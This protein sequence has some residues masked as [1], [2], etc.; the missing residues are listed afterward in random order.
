[1]KNKVVSAFFLLQISIGY[2]QV[3]FNEEQH[4]A[5]PDYSKESSWAA[6]PFR[7]DNA[8]EVP[9]GL[10]AEDDAQKVVDIFYI[11]PTTLLSGNQWNAAIDDAEINKQTDDRPIKYQATVFNENARV[12]APRYR[13]AHIRSFFDTTENG[14]LA[15][16]LAYADVKAAFLYFI[17]NHNDNRPFIIAS[18]SQGTYH[19]RRLIKELID[20]TNLRNRFIMGYLVGYPV[21]EQDYKHIKACENTTQTGCIAS[22]STYRDGFEPVRGDVFYKNAIVTNPISWNN[23]CSDDERM[24]KGMVLLNFNKIISGKV[25][26][27]RHKNYIWTKTNFPVIK[28]K[29]NLHIVD[30]NLFWLDIRQDVKRRIGYFWK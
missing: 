20:T 21:F 27:C 3:S 11:H 17:K 5:N 15:L 24:H 1:M 4:P 10:S 25:K 23:T 6:L 16:G 9:K 13:Q 22:W 7:K 30:I 2:S 26:A 18:H 28:T 8:D 12:Y 19:A 29:D 14:A